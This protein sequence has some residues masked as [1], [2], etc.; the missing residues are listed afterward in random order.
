MI[1]NI[2]TG[3]LLLVLLCSIGKLKAQT[4]N[5]GWAAYIANL[6]FKE[7]KFGL[8]FD[9][10]FRSSDD[11]QRLQQYLIRPALTYKFNKHYTVSAGYA[12]V[13][14]YAIVNGV[15]DRVSEHRAFEQFFINHKLGRVSLI[16]RFRNE[17]RWVSSAADPNNFNTQQRFRYFIRGLVPFGKESTF[18]QGFFG[19]FQEEVM[20][21]YINKET[22]NN[23]FFDQNRA[24]VGLGYRFNPK[25]DIEAGYMNQLVKQ[26]NG[27][28]LTNN[29]FQF[30]LYTRLSL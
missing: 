28:T 17:H 24:F 22:T 6:Q 7:S 4:Q 21:N 26:R 3:L 29:I 27:E 25:I 12:Y 13:S 10:Q 8:M 23:S 16:H 2:K 14:N 30:A 11:Y 9:A 5:S 18:N 15:D 1:K 19:S 20:F